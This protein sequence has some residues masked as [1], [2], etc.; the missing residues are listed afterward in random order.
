M[1]RPSFVWLSPTLTAVGKRFGIDTH[2][3]AKNG[4]IVT[5]GH[6]VT[7]LRGFVTGYVV[8]RFFDPQV[9]GQF[10]FM[11][12]V[13]GTLGVFAL[14]GMPHSVT[15]AWARGDAFSLWG[16]MRP[17][18]LCTL[19][20][21]TVLLGSIPF[22][23]RF[24]REEF[25]GMFAVAAL[26][27]PL[28]PLAMVHFGSYVVGKARFDVALK[29]T[30][31]SSVL[32]ILVTCAIIAFRQSA[33]LLL[34]ASM[35]IT[36]LVQLAFSRGV[37]PPAEEGTK[38]TDAIVRY[39]WQLTFATLPSELVWYLDKLL[40]SYFFGLNELA[41]FSVALLIPEQAKILV[42]QFFPLT[43]ARQAANGDSRARRMHLLRIVLAATGFFAL[44]IVAYIAV[45]PFA[46][47]WLF[48][49]YDAG[50]IVLLSGIAAITLITVPSTLIT[51]YLEAQGMIREVRHTT[52][53]A[54]GAFAVA[55]LALVPTLGPLGA[56]LARGVFRL[57]NST[58]A[59][60][61]LWRAP[62]RG[63]V[64]AS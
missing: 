62:I 28:A 20:V 43:F 25:A 54:T 33:F 52:W 58:M 30:I 7:I 31:I 15:R 24:G 13:L 61:F 23:G 63:A 64:S 45:S 59:A 47:P 60:W 53:I 11:L 1:R 3:Y 9:Y 14:S 35:T 55:L 34:L 46:M 40:I 22:L 41:V 56:V 48:P 32:M 17:Q 36:P 50:R 29:V 8:A 57:A 38:N 12:S 37:R 2:Y 49:S 16:V 19:A 42:K 5:V 44:G 39:A 6:A 27:F 10:Q 4:A 21:S 18:V 26:L 51:Q